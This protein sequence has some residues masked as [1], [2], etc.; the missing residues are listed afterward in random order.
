MQAA[1]LGRRIDWR[2][3]DRLSRGDFVFWEG[4]VGIMTSPDRFLHA[5][6]HHM[7]VEI[8]SF[9]EAKDRIKAAGYEV[10]CVRRLP[11]AGGQPRRRAD[12]EDVEEVKQDD[13]RDRDADQPQKNTAHGRSLR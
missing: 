10:M 1:E 13:D 3:G 9:A 7:A 8:E 5:N 2:E 4:H 11:Q 12:L 6:A